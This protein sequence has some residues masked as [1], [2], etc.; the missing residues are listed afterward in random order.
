MQIN[1]SRLYVE[2]AWLHSL[3]VILSTLILSTFDIV[4]LQQRQYLALIKWK[5]KYHRVTKE[6]NKAIFSIKPV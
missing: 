5:L 6:I 1:R 4:Y 2:L 3:F